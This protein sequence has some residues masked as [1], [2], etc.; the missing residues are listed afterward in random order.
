MQVVAKQPEKASSNVEQFL[1]N[2][3]HTSDETIKKFPRDGDN[4]DRP[5]YRV[6]MVHGSEIG[7]TGT[8]LA[9]QGSSAGHPQVAVP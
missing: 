1:K 4:V 6:G 9:V 8:D 5:P 3:D 7:L 2:A